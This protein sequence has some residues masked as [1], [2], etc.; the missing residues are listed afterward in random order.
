MQ[1]FNITVVNLLSQLD[2][3]RPP[4]Y[5]SLERVEDENTRTATDT[6]TA[7]TQL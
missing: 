1:Q 7:H 5:A 6:H 3:N 4:I 2:G